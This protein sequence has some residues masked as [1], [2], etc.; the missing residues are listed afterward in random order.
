M[1]IPRWCVSVVCGSEQGGTLHHR[2]VAAGARDMQRGFYFCE[3]VGDRGLV[4]CPI[5]SW[6][7]K[8]L[9]TPDLE[10][11]EHAPAQVV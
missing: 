2:S 7:E 11:K 10:V 9:L 6:D 8:S 5:F 3:V 4:L 1:T